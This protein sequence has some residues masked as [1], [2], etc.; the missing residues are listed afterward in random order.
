M[1]LSAD[2]PQTPIDVVLVVEDNM[3]IA[4]D[5][6]DIL[7]GLGAKRVIICRTCQEGLDALVTNDVQIA[8]LDVHLGEETSLDVARALLASRKPFL[9]VTGSSAHG[10]AVIDM[11]DVPTLSKP[12]TAYQLRTAVNQLLVR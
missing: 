9:F 10:G 8:L 4:L 6:E 2:A 5:I 7:L 12:F 1:N 11:P 3:I